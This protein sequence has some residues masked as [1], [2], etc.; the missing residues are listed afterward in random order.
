M[1]TV[2]IIPGSFAPAKHY[3]L[4]ADTLSQ[5]GIASQIID[6]PSV[7][8]HHGLPPQT[9]SDDVAEIVRVVEPLLDAG[10]QVVLMT[11]SYG[12]I[13]GTQSL[14]QLSRKA[15]EA[16]GKVGGVDKIVY[17]TSVVVQVGVANLDLF[18]DNLPDSITI[19]VRTSTSH[20]LLLT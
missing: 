8:K 1:A 15:R 6:I 2:A 3:D 5:H 4:F 11:H 12:G 16:E 18:G 10:R 19:N 7:G 9:M 14:K 20:K 13:P 17:V